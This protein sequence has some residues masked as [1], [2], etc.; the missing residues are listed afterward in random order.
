MVG[1]SEEPGGAQ[2][3]AEL[4]AELNDAKVLG[5]EGTETESGC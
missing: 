4:L 2:C 3:E 1:I 5:L